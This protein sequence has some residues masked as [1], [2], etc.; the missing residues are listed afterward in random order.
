MPRVALNDEIRLSA[1]GT[2]IESRSVLERNQS[3]IVSLSIQDPEAQRVPGCLMTVKLAETYESYM[4]PAI[5][6]PLAAGGRKM[7]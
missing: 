4:V 7:A 5:F 6:A 1:G 3:L 2:L